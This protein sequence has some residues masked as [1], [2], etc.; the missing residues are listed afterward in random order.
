MIRIIAPYFF[1]VQPRSICAT[2]HLFFM[3]MA[4]PMTKLLP[5]RLAPSLCMSFGPTSERR[6]ISSSSRSFVD[7]KPFANFTPDSTYHDL[8]PKYYVSINSYITYRSRGRGKIHTRNSSNMTL[9]RAPYVVN[10]YKQDPPPHPSTSLT[11]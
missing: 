1:V 10:W 3:D 2:V 5:M 9:R 7:L 8:R 11:T 6:R 4:I